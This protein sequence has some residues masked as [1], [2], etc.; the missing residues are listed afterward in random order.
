MLERVALTGATGFVGK[1]VLA[2]LEK[3]GYRINVLTRRP[4]P[5]SG[6]VSWISGDLHNPAALEKLVQGSTSIIHCAGATRGN[7]LQDFLKV[8]FA[9]TKNLLEAAGNM[10]R[11]PRFLLISSLAARY[12]DY[13]WYARSKAM[14][15]TLL[16]SDE[17]AALARTIYRPTAV[18]GPGDRE[19]RPLFRLMRRGALAGTGAPDARLSLIHVADLVN[20]I[21][22]WLQ[23]QDAQGLFELDDGAPEG[24]RWQDIATL[25]EAAWKR[26]I[27]HIRVPTPLLRWTARANLLLARTLRYPAMLTPG[28]V[29]ELTH[30]DWVCDNTPLT[31][32]LGWKPQIGLGKGIH[33]AI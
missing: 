23:A 1:H 4:H 31:T 17:Y 7:S 8:N 2:T 3:S 30:K 16:M 25:G 13:S 5:D 22:M 19:M 28:K 27:I 20:A 12:P 24:Y 14:A 15:E 26:H 10:T 32:R 18:Y 11:A 9:G 6:S 21:L 33:T 29:N